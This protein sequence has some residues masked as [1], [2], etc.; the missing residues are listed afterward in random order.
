[1]STLQHAREK[2]GIGRRKP[3]AIVS[4]KKFDFLIRSAIKSFVSKSIP[5]DAKILGKKYRLKHI[6]AKQLFDKLMIERNSDVVWTGIET[7]KQLKNDGWEKEISLEDQLRRIRF[8]LQQENKESTEQT[9]FKEGFV[10]LISN[11]NWSKWIKV[12][13]TLD[14][15]SRLSSYNIYDPTFGYEYVKIAFTND[16]KNKEKILIELFEDASLKRSGEWFEIDQLEAIKIFE[17]EIKL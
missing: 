9:K 8:I 3:K 6:Q 2:Y 10:Y 12:G 17:K 5:F 13:M 11:K 15:E 14:Y 4:E 7:K 16:R 1:M